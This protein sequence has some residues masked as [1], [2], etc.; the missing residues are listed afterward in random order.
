MGRIFGASNCGSA[1]VKTG[2]NSKARDCQARC[3]EVREAGG[4]ESRTVRLRLNDWVVDEHARSENGSSRSAY[5][6]QTR[7]IAMGPCL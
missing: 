6:D 4:V 2:R 5:V 1:E 7:S 3:V